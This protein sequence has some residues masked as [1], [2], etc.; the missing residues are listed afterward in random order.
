M[1]IVQVLVKYMIFRYLDPQG[2][3]KAFPHAS[4][5]RK[6]DTYFRLLRV[7]DSGFVAEASVG[8]GRLNSYRVWADQ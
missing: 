7:Q 1:I 3:N 2:Y 8:V 5:H 4:E 6:E